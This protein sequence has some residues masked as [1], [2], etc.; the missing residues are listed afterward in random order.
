MKKLLLIIALI[1][2]GFLLSCN[3]Q[4]QPGGDSKA[5]ITAPRNISAKEAKAMMDEG[6]PYTLLDVRTAGEYSSGHIKGA[7]LIP[8]TEIASRA[9]KELPDKGAVILIYCRSGVRAA[10]AAQIL[11]GMGYTNVYNFGGIMDWPY[12]TVKD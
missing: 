10:N 7:I 2:F 6:K 11:A 5:N 9:G 4:E 8:N 12:E 1:P 3:A